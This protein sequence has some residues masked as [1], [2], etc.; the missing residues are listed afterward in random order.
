MFKVGDRVK[1]GTVLAEITRLPSPHPYSDGYATIKVLPRGDTCHSRLEFLT[2]VDD[3]DP[4]GFYAGFG[5]PDQEPKE[6]EAAVRDVSE[7]A[8]R[9]G[10]PLARG[11]LYYAPDALAYVA[12]VSRVGNDQ[13]NPGEP[14]H[15]AKTKSPDHGDCIL[16]H[17]ADYDE[18]DTDGLLHAGKVAWRA[19]MQLQTLLER[20]DPKLAERRQAQRDRQAKGER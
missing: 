7:H 8:K 5:W 18:P 20:R 14:I 15:W 13:H 11:V 6:V 12:E 3:K 16:R 10:Q 2:A 4:E 17:Q 9:K 19:L 1:W